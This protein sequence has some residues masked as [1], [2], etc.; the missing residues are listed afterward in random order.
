MTLAEKNKADLF[1][2]NTCVVFISMINKP[3]TIKLA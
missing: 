2:K 1:S 3:G